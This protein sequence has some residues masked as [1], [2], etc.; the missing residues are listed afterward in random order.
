MSKPF[1]TWTV[2]PHEP[3]V[4][5]GDEILAVTG[6]L[7][8]PLGQ[9]ERRMTVVRLAD[10]R[11]VVFSAIA[12]DEAE[13]TELEYFG[14]PAFL[15]VPS[16]IHR[17]DAKPWKD[18]YPQ[19]K[20]IAP[21][22]ARAKVEEVVKVDATTVDFGDPTVRFVTVPGTDEREAALVVERS[23]QTTLIVADLVFN[24]PKQRGIRGIISNAIGISGD[25]PHLPSVVKRVRVKD[26]RAFRAQLEAW[27]HLPNL[28][29]IVV[30]HGEIITRDPAH[31][32]EDIAKRIAA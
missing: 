24:I 18:R 19:L 6:K 16:D 3:V 9:I 25:H 32:L 10:A 20:V 8:M 15:I 12:L 4:D 31:V 17:M 26:K 14:W 2:L 1:K 11:L 27:A 13:M 7:H 5:L 28:A 21:A 23:G 22:G 29:R 30:A